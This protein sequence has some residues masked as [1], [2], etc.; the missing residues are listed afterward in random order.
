MCGASINSRVRSM[1]LWIS[2]HDLRALFSYHEIIESEGKKQNFT[3]NKI[4][5]KHISLWM[6]GSSCSFLRRPADS[7]RRPLDENCNER[8]KLQVAVMRSESERRL[9]KGNL[10]P[11]YLLEWS[12]REKEK[13]STD[14]LW[15]ERYKLK[16]ERDTS[17]RESLVDS[18]RRYTTG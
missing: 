18:K 6:S 10:I 3:S 2:M 13:G 4:S 12:N 17:R 14:G 15:L 9:W 16:S 1:I 5:N 11:E 7:H 8:T